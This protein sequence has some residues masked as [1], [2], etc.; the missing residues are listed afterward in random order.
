MEPITTF[1]TLVL[2]ASILTA[3]KT[4]APRWRKNEERETAHWIETSKLIPVSPTEN[5]ISIVT[6]ELPRAATVLS[7]LAV[8]PPAK[9]A[10]ELTTEV[11]F[12]D[13]K[14]KLYAKLI[15]YLPDHPNGDPS[16]VSSEED[17]VTSIRF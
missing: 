4:A 10:K 16:I 12:V 5:T 1:S 9:L 6:S 3:P 11:P 13:L 17:I 15:S 7:P 14:E 8:S 2:A